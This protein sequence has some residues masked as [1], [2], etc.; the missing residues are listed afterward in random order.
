[1]VY[2][3]IKIEHIFVRPAELGMIWAHVGHKTWSKI[4]LPKKDKILITCW[5]FFS[6]HI[7]VC[8]Y[9]NMFY[10]LRIM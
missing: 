3:L 4:F 8:I 2:F 10:D 9:V 6:V 5:K 1:M 7:F